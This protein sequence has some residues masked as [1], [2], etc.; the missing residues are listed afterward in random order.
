MFEA[1]CHCFLYRKAAKTALCIQLL[2]GLPSVVG[3]FFSTDLQQHT[4]FCDLSM[5]S[6]AYRLFVGE[7]ER[8]L[9]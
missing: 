7:C 4:A 3:A 8:G 5:T 6:R 1:P 2:L 9:A